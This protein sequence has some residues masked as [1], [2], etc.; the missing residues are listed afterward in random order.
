MKFNLGYN[1]RYVLCSAHEDP[2][3]MLDSEDVYDTL[4]S[5][6][7]MRENYIRDVPV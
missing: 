6:Q 4:E 2:I 1:V 7:D 3:K 5:A